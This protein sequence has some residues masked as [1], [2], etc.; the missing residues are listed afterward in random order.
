MKQN[1]NN[2]TNVGI[3]QR[4]ISMEVRALISRCL[5]IQ[6]FTVNFHSNDFMKLK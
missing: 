2:S 4:K 1:K 6:Y 3:Q 5:G